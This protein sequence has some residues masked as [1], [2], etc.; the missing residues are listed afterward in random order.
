M[1]V[2]ERYECLRCTH[3]WWERDIDADDARYWPVCPNEGC[4]AACDEVEMVDQTD[5]NGAHIPLL[6]ALDEPMD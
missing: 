1:K 6:P 2:N 4:G 3:T 5:E